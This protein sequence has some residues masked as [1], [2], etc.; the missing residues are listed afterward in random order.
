MNIHFN[1][2]EL[3]SN[4]A[5]RIY[6]LDSIQEISNFAAGTILTPQLKRETSSLF[7]DLLESTNWSRSPLQTS[8][9]LNCKTLLEILQLSHS[10]ER[11]TVN[12]K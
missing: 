6:S 1:P 5:T 2:V 12:P 8:W 10:K 9:S 11:T 7:L 4:A 3:L